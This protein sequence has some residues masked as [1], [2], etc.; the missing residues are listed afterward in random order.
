[1]ILFW[2][3]T[4]IT[5]IEVF[6]ILHLFFIDFITY[7][8]CPKGWFWVRFWTW[9]LDTIMWLTCP[10]FYGNKISYDME[11]EFFNSVIYATGT[12]NRFI[13]LIEFYLYLFLLSILLIW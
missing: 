2:V 3:L 8:W 13:A 5:T 11:V 4:V 6:I 10:W 12:W 9:F 1:L 7:I